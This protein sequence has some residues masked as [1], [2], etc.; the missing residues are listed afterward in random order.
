MIR[1]P[2]LEQLASAGVKLGLE[3]VRSFLGHLGEPQLACPS[4]HVAGTNGKGSTCMMVTS[5]LVAAGYRVGTHLSPHLEAINERVRF[6]GTPIDDATLNALIEE[7][8]RHRHDWARSLGEAH[9]PL[10][11]FEFMTVLSMLAFAQRGVDVA[12]HEVGMGGRLDATNV[13]RPVV[14]SIVTVGLDHMEELGDTVDKIAAEKAG[15]LKRGVPAVIG[16]LPEEARDVVEARARRLECDL[17]RPGPQLRREFRK[18]K[19]SFFTPEG[20]VVGVDLPLRGDHMGHNAMVAVGVLHRMRKLGFL[21]PDD[22]IVTGLETVDISGRIEE[23]LPGLLADGAHNVDGARALAAWLAARE[24]PE[25]RVLLFGLGQNRDPLPILA[26]LV[27]H[28]DEIV[29]TRCDHPKAADPMDIAVRLQEAGLDAVLSAGRNI[30]EDLPEIYVEADET[31][32]AGSLFLAGAA[33]SLVR[34][35]ALDGLTPG[36]VDAPPDDDGEE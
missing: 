16:L 5:C 4:V 29:T 9:A 36:S 18:G 3:R 26:P 34:A 28:F 32:V 30:D 7:L 14:T 21:I 13:L 31:V 8:D 10:T 22:A 15:I 2:V 27:E 17:W 1:H 19:W 24:R 23:L 12:V 35:G 33:R 20:S 6:D 25:R 11:Y